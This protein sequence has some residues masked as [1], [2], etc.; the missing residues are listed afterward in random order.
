MEKSL[1]STIWSYA[2][3]FSN[4]DFINDSL[5]CQ[6]L[7]P[8]FFIALLFFK[9][10]PTVHSDPQSQRIRCVMLE[11]YVITQKFTPFFDVFSHFNVCFDQ[12]F[13]NFSLPYNEQM[14][15]AKIREIMYDDDIA[16]LQK[17]ESKEFYYFILKFSKYYHDNV[18]FLHLGACTNY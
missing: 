2:E 16:W 6:H 11:R 15:F 8:T 14:Q 17:P 5:L 13:L 4:F 9:S 7:V 12:M 1:L 10:K 3:H 18:L